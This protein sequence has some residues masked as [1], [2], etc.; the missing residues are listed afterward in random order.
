MKLCI[1]F[2]L[3]YLVQLDKKS[4]INTILLVNKS[5]FIFNYYYYFTKLTCNHRKHEWNVFKL[6][7]GGSDLQILKLFIHRDMC[8]VLRVSYCSAC[9][10]QMAKAMQDIP[11][12]KKSQRKNTWTSMLA[13]LRKIYTFKLIA[14]SVC[15]GY[16]FT[17]VLILMKQYW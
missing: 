15:S 16:V 14:L 6:L 11:F 3:Q 2:F 7:A 1:S 8:D 4:Q 12:T 13:V 5:T 9:G 17:I 10:P